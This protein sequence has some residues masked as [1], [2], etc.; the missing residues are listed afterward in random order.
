MKLVS[1]NVGLPRE[2]QWH[3]KTVL[4]SISKAPVAGPIAVRRMNVEGDR[5]SDLEVHGEPT[6]PPTSTRR[7]TTHSGA[8]SFPAWT[9]PGRFRREFHD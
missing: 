2:V 7:S 4:T 3:G 1:I 8:P 9:F 5:Q 6:R